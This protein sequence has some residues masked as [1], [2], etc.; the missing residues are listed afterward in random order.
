MPIK[1]VSAKHWERKVSRE[2]ME[3]LEQISTEMG[4]EIHD[5]LLQRLTIF[6]FYLDRLERE[7]SS[8]EAVEALVTEMKGEYE[9][10]I[11]SVRKVTRQLMPSHMEQETFTKSIHLLCLSLERPG[12]GHI[13][14]EHNGVEHTLHKA[15]ETYLSRI[16]QEL[17]HN[18]FKHSSAWHVW[19]RMNWQSDKLLIEIE[20]DGT[21]FMETKE[22]IARLNTKYNT[23]RMRADAISAK[24]TYTSG[25]K[26]LLARIECPVG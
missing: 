14:F 3:A 4:A 7:A 16:V 18:A 22:A 17:I 12:A 21:G 23:L 6:R 11:Q 13:H 8:Q 20:D 26:G 10:I 25:D 9:D 5:D 1:I 15:V 2:A 19:V 24:I